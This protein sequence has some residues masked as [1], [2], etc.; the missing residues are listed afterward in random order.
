MPK[1]DET[2]MVREGDGNIAEVERGRGEEGLAAW[3]DAYQ[4][5]VL[6]VRELDRR[7]K[8]EFGLP[9]ASYEVLARLAALPEGRRMRMQELAR[10]AF[11]SKSGISQLFTRLEKRGLVERRG[12]P[13][14][15][16]VTYATITG[17]GR[18]ALERAAPT[19]REEVEERFARHLDDEELGVLRRVMRK[20]IRGNG[21]EP[22][23]DE[24]QDDA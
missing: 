15:L 16:R 6:V 9:L 14:N 4:A 21:D 11:L 24:P 12:D 17:E 18:E 3:S 13:E 20:M 1:G 2:K 23:T 19:F 22:L 8:E 5:Q 7:L 10:K